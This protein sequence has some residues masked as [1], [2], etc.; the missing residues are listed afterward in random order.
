MKLK[1]S[2]ITKSRVFRPLSLALVFGLVACA[3]SQ[4]LVPETASSSS[5]PAYA[6][7]WPERLK[8]IRERYRESAELARS[9]TKTFTSFPQEYEDPDWS[10]VLQSIE[11]ADEAGRSLA[12]DDQMRQSREVRL[13]LDENERD[14]ARRVISHVNAAMKNTS[15]GTSCEYPGGMS[16]SRVI[17]DAASKAL[18]ERYHELNEAHRHLAANEEGLS[19]REVPILEAQIDTITVT[20]HFVSVESVRLRDEIDRMLEEAETVGETLDKAI[21]VERDAGADEGSSKRAQ[22]AS[23]EQL[24]ALQKARDDVEG[25]EHNARLERENMDEDIIALREEYRAAFERLVEALRSRTEGAPAE[26]EAAEPAG[27]DAS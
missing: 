24:E 14:I 15:S 26:E 21:A 27:D 23:A 5:S 4:D 1:T 25:I 8:T 7:E 2:R 16:V 9:D 18:E 12:L 10:V 19:K 6:R 22:E 20:S 11:L 13:F 3:G 17:Q